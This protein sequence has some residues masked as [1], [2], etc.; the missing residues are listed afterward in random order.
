MVKGNNVI[1]RYG[2]KKDWQRYIVT[3]FDQPGRKVRRRQARNR[4]AAQ[5]FPRPVSGLLRPMAHG[6]TRRYNMKIK[7][8][9]GFTKEELKE[10]GVAP[11][12]ARTIGIAV[13][14]RRKN[15]SLELL[16][17]NAARLKEYMAKL[18][19]FPRRQSK[20]R[21]GDSAPE[22]TATADQLKGDLMKIRT[23][24]PEEMKAV[25]TTTITAEQKAFN[26]Y[27]KLRTERM[28]VRQVGARKKRAEDEAREAEEKAKAAK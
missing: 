11:A 14:H 22:V 26:A 23:H 24:A 2:N 10:A 4:K 5:V 15:R 9:R 1:P 21:K 19:L 12:I 13:D 7:S 16:Q 6:Q 25:E 3:W 20:P 8:G 27:Q 17:Q 18:V 28:N